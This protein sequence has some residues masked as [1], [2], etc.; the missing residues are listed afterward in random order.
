[1]MAVGSPGWAVIW[2]SCS[3]RQRRRCD[4]NSARG[5]TKKKPASGVKKRQQKR[6][7]LVVDEH[8][9]DWLRAV[10][11]GWQGEKTLVLAMDART[12]S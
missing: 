3:T 9:A 5:M 12:L 2:L 4:K 10:I 8:F 7:E 1:L 11:T 6:R